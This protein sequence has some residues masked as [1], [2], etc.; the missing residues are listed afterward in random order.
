MGDIAGKS[1]LSPEHDELQDVNL[2]MLKMLGGGNI[3]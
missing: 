1:T 2:M 3:V